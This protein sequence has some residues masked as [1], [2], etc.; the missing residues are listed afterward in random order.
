MEKFAADLIFTPGPGSRYWRS[1]SQNKQ[2][3][4]MWEGGGVLEPR[5][6]EINKK[7]YH[8]LTQLS[9][10]LADVTQELGG[11]SERS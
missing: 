7:D 1:V 11:W 6:G 8:S 2:L 10:F 3:W 5:S 9:G 4:N